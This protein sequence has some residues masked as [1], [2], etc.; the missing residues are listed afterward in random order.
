[1]I[2]DFIRADFYI[3]EFMLI[4]EIDG[5]SHENGLSQLNKKSQMKKMVLEQLGYTVCNINAI[6]FM[7]HNLTFGET[8]IGERYI[9]EQIKHALIQSGNQ[10]MPPGGFGFEDI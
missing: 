3:P 4:I 7:S 6:K 5:P 2:A 8:N 1:M 9:S 10:R